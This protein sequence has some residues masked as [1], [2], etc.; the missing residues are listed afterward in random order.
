MMR[1]A[2][3]T[4][5]LARRALRESMRQPALEFGNIFIPLF[6]FAVVVG[7]IGDASGRAFGVANYT[8]FQLPIAILQGVAG[9]SGNSGLG[10]V[11]DIERGYF[12]KLLLTPA[13]RITLVLGRLGADVVRVTVL[14]TLILIAGLIAGSGMEA[15]IGGIAV[16]LLTSALFGVSYSCIGIALALK[17]GSAQAAQ[18]GFLIFFPLIF[19]SPAFAPEGGVRRLARVPGDDQPG[20]LHRRGAA[21]PGARRLGCRLARRLSRRDHGARRVHDHADAVGAAQPDAVAGSRPLHCAGGRLLDHVRRTRAFVRH[22]PGAGVHAVDVDGAGVLL[23]QVRRAVAAPDRRRRDRL[24][25]GAPGA[26]ADVPCRG[27]PRRWPAPG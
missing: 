6:F 7:A 14:T 8:G 3:D 22:Q 18:L 11:T 19:L 23:H 20:D 21:Q 26:G 10:T 13:S 25:T 4:Y 9:S 15:G 16:L 27:E 1:M 5:W 17:T 24:G 2:A 12:D